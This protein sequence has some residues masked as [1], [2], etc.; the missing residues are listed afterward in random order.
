MPLGRVQ[1]GVLVTHFEDGTPYEYQPQEGAATNVGWLDAANAYP[2]G[3]VPPEF[4]AVLTE[5]CR[6]GVL[7]MRGWH[8]CN[9]C[10]PD[11]ERR[12]Y[13]DLVP[14]LV[15]S[16]TGNYSVG[17]AEIRVPGLEGV[18]YAAP[19]MVIHYVVVHGYRPPDGFIEAVLGST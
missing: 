16:E 9:L 3:P 15:Q 13:S 12:S 10:V 18:V 11:G 4:I 14:T 17:D 1:E 2:Q 6:S 19:D 8:M 5:L 7:R